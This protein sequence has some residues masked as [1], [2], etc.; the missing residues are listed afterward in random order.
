MFYQ[1][2]DETRLIVAAQGGD[3]EALGLVMAQ[4]EPLCWKLVLQKRPKSSPDFEDLLQQSRLFLIESIHK[5]DPARAVKFITF[6]YCRISLLL[7]SELRTMG[8]IRYPNN[9]RAQALRRGMEFFGESLAME[10]VDPGNTLEEDAL[11]KERLEVVAEVVGMLPERERLVILGRMAGEGLEKI[12]NRLGICK[13]RVRQ[14][15]L[16][17]LRRL[18]RKDRLRGVA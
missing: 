15:E 13:E 2:E 1:P 7:I 8:L 6:A 3:R 11:A 9:S 10:A 16:V 18:Q 17:A 14:I 4:Y 12:G 5:Y